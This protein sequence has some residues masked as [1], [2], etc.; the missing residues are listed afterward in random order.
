MWPGAEMIAFADIISALK[1][2]A[3]GIKSLADS[4][5]R[6]DA[7]YDAAILRIYTAASESKIYIAGLKNRKNP[8]EN[9]ERKLTRLW[10]KAAVGLRNYD[11]DIADQCLVVGDSISE[12]TT[13]SRSQIDEARESVTDIF[14]QARRLL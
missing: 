4:K 9:R 2:V 8:D 13:W 7:K 5:E 1:M 10:N 12:S 3:G 11:K 6:K 14:D